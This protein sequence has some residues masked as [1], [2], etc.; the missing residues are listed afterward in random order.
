SCFEYCDIVVNLQPGT[1]FANDFLIMTSVRLYRMA[2]SN[3]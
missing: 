3:L 1:D 2:E